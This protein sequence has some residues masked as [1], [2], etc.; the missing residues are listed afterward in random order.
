MRDYY[1]LL[2]R[3]GL[4]RIRFHDL[5]HSTASLLIRLG[6]PSKIVSDIL[7]HSSIEV[8]NDTYTHIEPALQREAIR[9]LERALRGSGSA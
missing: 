7:G 3:A 1:P 5:R 8:T 2:A 9:E 6:V 4:P